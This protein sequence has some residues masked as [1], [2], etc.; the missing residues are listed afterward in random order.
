MRKHVLFIS[1]VLG[2]GSPLLSAGL[3]EPQEHEALRELNRKTIT[4]INQVD[5]KALEEVFTKP[6]DLTFA[7]QST[8][9]SIDELKTYYQ[10][11]TTQGGMASI[12]FSPSVD[13]LTRFI[14]DTVGIARGSSKDVFTRKDGKNLEL[15][16][17]WTATV[18]KTNGEWKISALHAGINLM[19]NAVL[20]LVTKELKKGTMFLAIITAL[21]G[22]GI[23]FF[24][25]RC[26]KKL[27]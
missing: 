22:F 13:Q 19:D 18:V 21:I 17:R 25:G 12:Q 1:V 8:I 24:F 27:I 26:R 10:E 9:H 3:K 5:F 7:D 2:I 15:E 20:R 11:M 23:G 6:F 14:S 4:A 16:S